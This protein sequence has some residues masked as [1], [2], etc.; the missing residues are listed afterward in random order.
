MRRQK[1]Y[2]HRFLQ[3]TISDLPSNVDKYVVPLASLLLSLPAFITP[4]YP[5]STS[6]IRP[7]PNIIDTI[8]CTQR[9]YPNP[10]VLIY[11]RK[12]RF[13]TLYISQGIKDKDFLMG[14]ILGYNRGVRRQMDK[15][16]CNGWQRWIQAET[17]DRTIIIH[18]CASLYFE[19]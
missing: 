12:G 11:N 8:F 2:S 6:P 17:L 14:L 3:P 4:I 1:R 18:R 13:V 7:P 15:P 19:A 5:H 9:T 16:T 10:S